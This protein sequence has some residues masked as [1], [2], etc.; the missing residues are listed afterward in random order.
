MIEGVTPL[1]SVAVAEKL[2]IWL[3]A[4]VIFDGHTGVGACVSV[5]V[6]LKVHCKF[7]LDAELV[8]V[9]VTVVV[10]PME[11]LVFEAFE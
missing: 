3:F 11:K 7:V 9:T 8:P 2:T 5:I 1:L 10:W 6:T 4:C